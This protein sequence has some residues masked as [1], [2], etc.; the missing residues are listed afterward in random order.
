MRRLILMLMLGLAL[1]ANAGNVMAESING[2]LGLNG[3]LGAIMPLEDGEI[4]GSSFTTDDVGFA[5]GGGL[6]YGFGDNLAAEL[7]VIHIDSLDVK[8]A[9]SK[10]GEA[11]FTDISVGLQYRMMPERRVVPYLGAGVDFIKGDIEDSKLDWAIGG[12]INGG[13]DFFLYPRLVLNLDVRGI[14]AEE[15]DIEL[16]DRKIGKFDPMSVVTTLGVRLFLPEKWW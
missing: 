7:D 9:G 11:S 15:N 13:I 6:I 5:G 10:V 2:K 14:I 4:E 16:D 1:A 3:K 8:M 12:H